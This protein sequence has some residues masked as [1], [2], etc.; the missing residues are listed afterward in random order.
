MFDISVLKYPVPFLKL[1]K[2]LFPTRILRFASD[3]IVIAFLITREIFIRIQFAEN[4]NYFSKNFCF[5]T[6]VLGGVK[7]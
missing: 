3:K 4:A 5:L 1:K 6:N 7:V 2:T